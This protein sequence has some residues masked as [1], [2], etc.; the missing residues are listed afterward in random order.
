[1]KSTGKWTVVYTKNDDYFMTIDNKTRLTKK[2]IKVVGGIP[3]RE[4]TRMQM[5]LNDLLDAK[6]D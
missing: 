2:Y 5:R 3:L 4:A 6:D 1:M